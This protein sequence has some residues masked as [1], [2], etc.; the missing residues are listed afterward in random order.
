[1]S[2]R[3]YET[4]K[5][6]STKKRMILMIIG[7]LVLIAIIALIKVLMVRQMMA[8]FSKPQPPAVVSTAIAGYQPWQPALSAV[9]TLRA[10]RG[11]DLALDVSGL[12]TAVNLKSGDDVKQGQVLLQLRDSEDVAQLHQLQAAAALAKVTFERASQQLAVQAISK[13]GYD[14]AAADYKAKQAAVAQ[15]E[16]NVDKKQLR[17]PFSGRAGIVTLN[18]GAFLNS[19]TTIVTLQQV[20]SLYVDFYVPQRELARVHAGQKVVLKLDAFGK[21]EFDGQINAINPKVD[22]DTRNVLV[23]ATVPNQDGTL[24]PGMFANVSVDVGGQ[25]RYLTLPQTAIVYNPYGETV[26]VAMS[27][28][29]FEKAQ[30]EEAAKNGDSTDA[31]A[32]GNDGKKQDKANAPAPDALVVRQTFVTT[33]ATRGDQVAVL[34]GIREGAQVVTSGQLKLKNGAPIKVD[35]QFRPSDNPNPNPQED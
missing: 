25:A 26:Y 21:R 22:N 3:A 19:G 14:D 10:V 5:K 34:T 18:P 11:A 12:V 23:E 35:N 31:G 15:Q 24:T 33:G 7:V 1:M 13:A 32:S 8:A 9:G 17:A 20:D 27:E 2:T 16:V 29:E 30:S 6:P 4:Q 28:R